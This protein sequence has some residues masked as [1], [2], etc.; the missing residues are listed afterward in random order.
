MEGR[1]TAEAQPQTVNTPKVSESIS[2]F[3]STV[4]PLYAF[5]DKIKPVLESQ[6]KNF[7]AG[8]LALFHDY[9]KTLTSDRSILDTV[10]GLSLELN[11]YPYQS[12]VPSEYKFTE[13]EMN[14]LDSEI[15][16]MLGKQIIAKVDWQDEQ[17][18]SN[19]FLRDK[20]D[21]TFRMILNLSNL[22]EMIDYHKFKMDTLVSAL[23]LITPN[24]YMA[25]IDYKDA[26]Y[27]VPVRPDQRKWLRFTFKGIL[28]EF[29]CLPNGLTSGPR[30]FT[31][32]TKP[33][34]AKLR[35][36]GHLNSPYIDD[37]ILV[38]E[39]WEECA[40]NVMDTVEV[41]MDSGWV[42]HPGKSIFIPTQMLEFLGFWI[43]SVNMIVILTERKALTIREMCIAM[44]SY[45]KPTIRTVAQLVGKL[46]ASFPAVMYGKLFYRILDNE[47][48]LALKE[49]FGNFDAKMRISDLAKQDLKWWIDNILFTN[50]PI[51]HAKPSV[52]VFSDASLLGWGGVLNGVTTGG[53][54]SLSEQ[55]IH[56]NVLELIAA[57]YVLA[58]LCD[59][60]SNCHIR[61]MIDNKTAVSY[62]NGMG[63]RKSLCNTIARKIWLWCKDRNIWLSVAYIA[64]KDNVIADKMSRISHQNSEWELNGDIFDK[65]SRLLGKPTID[66]FASRLNNKCL[67][68]VA[69]QP[70]PFAFATDAFTLDWENE[71]LSYIFPPFCLIG[72]ILQKI[73]FD[74]ANVIMVVPY[75]T[76][77]PW[78]SKLL[79]LLTTCPLSFYRNKQTLRHPHKDVGELPRMLMLACSLS[80]I[81]SRQIRYHNKHNT[82]SCPLGGGPLA[83]NT[84]CISTDGLS[85]QIGQKSIFIHR[86]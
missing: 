74:K 40:V 18:V 85:L 79:R 78:W 36:K 60:L 1:W 58:S 39:T 67:K 81:C 73:D 84:R 11:K 71:D 69:F 26:Y 35:E 63:G 12:F 62:I 32:L 25:S 44:L 64:S 48:S 75:W 8:R 27:S 80:G 53:N 31:K 3:Q 14:A 17:Y 15:E 56:I 20:K 52:T 24:C 9:W 34:F 10:K 2:N 23:N 66:L 65:I 82:L 6:V 86:L 47:K 76:T 28:Y 5:V 55:S 30:L 51:V 41:S 49:N 83:G 54:W 29:T 19:I 38:G 37:S 45:K 72:R 68:Y 16:K 70:D 43:D 4:S 13:Q 50:C 46:V 42:V 61:M 21:G 33:V 77:Q 57:Q 59:K 22:N 7:K